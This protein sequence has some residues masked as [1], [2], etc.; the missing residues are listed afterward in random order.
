MILGGEQ[1]YSNVDIMPSTHLATCNSV[2]QL[3]ESLAAMSNWAVNLWITIQ[4]ITF[5]RCGIF[6]HFEFYTIRKIKHSLVWVQSSP[7]PIIVLVFIVY[8]I[9]LTNINNILIVSNSIF[10]C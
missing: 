10:D 6:V 3:A 4:L 1:I 2:S 7:N 5:K 9:Y 8:Y